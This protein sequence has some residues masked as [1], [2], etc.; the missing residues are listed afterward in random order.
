MKLFPTEFLDHCKKKGKY[1]QNVPSD[2]KTV[3]RMALG[4]GLY[5]QVV[6]IHRRNLDD[7]KKDK[8]KTFNFQGRSERTKQW[9][10]IDH[11]WLKHN[12]MTRA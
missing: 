5:E 9:F 10:D 1:P 3:I 4:P 6:M 2:V 11:E 8:T 7:I 12:F